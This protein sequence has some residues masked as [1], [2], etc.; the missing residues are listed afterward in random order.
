M[1]VNL[2]FLN[3]V[4]KRELRRSLKAL[5]FKLNMVSSDFK[6]DAKTIK[7]WKEV[8]KN[9]LDKERARN[10]NQTSDK[11]SD[12]TLFEELVLPVSLGGSGIILLIVAG[13]FVYFCM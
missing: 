7:Y 4:R 11:T 9:Y 12:E 8:V 1:F 13:L 3:F 5:M 10:K 6:F 2:L